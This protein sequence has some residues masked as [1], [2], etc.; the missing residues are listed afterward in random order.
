VIKIECTHKIWPIILLTMQLICFS[1]TIA[2]AIPGYHINDATSAARAV[3]EYG[4]NPANFEACIYQAEL[5]KSLWRLMLAAHDALVAK[6]KDAYLKCCFAEAYWRVSTIM[7]RTET[8]PKETIDAMSSMS[9][10][11]ARDTEQGA[12]E[13]PQCAVGKSGPI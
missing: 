13:L 12:V 7:G 8:V 2:S 9:S 3:K 6:P 1:A 5:D 4:H 10:E 11:A